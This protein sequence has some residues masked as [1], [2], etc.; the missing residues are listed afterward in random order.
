MTGAPG[1]EPQAPDNSA[2]F[3]KFQLEMQ[4]QIIRN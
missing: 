3:Q 4:L 1:G 2:E